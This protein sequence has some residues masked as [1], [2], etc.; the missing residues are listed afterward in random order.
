MIPG[1]AFVL[2]G[3]AGLLVMVRDHAKNS[4]IHLLYLLGLAA[5]LTWAGLAYDYDRHNSKSTIQ[6]SVRLGRYEFTMLPSE[7]RC[8]MP[9]NPESR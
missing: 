1:M 2:V 4:Q 7:Q 8:P 3:L 5:L 6:T 9:W